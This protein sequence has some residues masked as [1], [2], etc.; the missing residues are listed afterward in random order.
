MPTGHS[1]TVRRQRLGAQL[2]RLRLSS[3]MT[4][5]DVAAQ[6]NWSASKVSRIE[7]ARVRTTVDDVRALLDLYRANETE[8]EELLAVAHDAAT[9]PE[10]WNAYADI[11]PDRQRVLVDLEAGVVRLRHFQPQVVP[12]LLQVEPYARRVLHAAGLTRHAA[13]EPSELDKAV[14][15]RVARQAILTHPDAPKYEVILDEAVLR[16]TVGGHE[17]MR[18]QIAH[19]L[20]VSELTNVS[21]QVLPLE[22]ASDPLVT[23]G[24]VIYDFRDTDDPDTVVVETMTTDLHLREDS[25]VDV[26]RRVFERLQAA[27]LTPY[28]TRSFLAKLTYRT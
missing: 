2:R 4:G 9:R 22:A 20:Q 23:S 5:D 17:V 19:L 1:S 13:S 26:Y 14:A 18:A 10:W 7:T 25:D 24:F 21:V 11:L 27:S 8:R 3:G 16:R 15:A 12:G 6:L 28:T